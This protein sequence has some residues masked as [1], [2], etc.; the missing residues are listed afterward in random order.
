MIAA[1]IVGLYG[2]FQFEFVEK[3]L[4]KFESERSADESSIPDIPDT[5][6]APTVHNERCD[7]DRCTKPVM[8]DSEDLSGE[9]IEANRFSDSHWRNRR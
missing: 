6:E 9:E 8:D 4:K 5:P 2:L 7:C 1:V 3:Y